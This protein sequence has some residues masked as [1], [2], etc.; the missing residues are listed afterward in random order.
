MP[1]SQTSPMDQKTQFIGDYLR[2][3]IRELEGV[4]ELRPADG[5]HGVLRAA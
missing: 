4:D 2:G 5:S 1:W 3:K